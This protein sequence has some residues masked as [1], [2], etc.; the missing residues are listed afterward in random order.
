VVKF[1]Q[2]IQFIPIVERT[3]ETTFGDVARSERQIQFG[4]DRRETFPEAGIEPG[5]P[6]TGLDVA[7]DANSPT[8]SDQS[9]KQSDSS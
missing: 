5:G 1:I 2:F 4:R 9:P 8:S 7:T 6:T 3:T